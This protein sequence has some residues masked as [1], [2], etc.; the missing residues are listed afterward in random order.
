MIWKTKLPH[1]TPSDSRMSTVHN[2]RV[3][4]TKPKNKETRH[5]KTRHERLNKRKIKEES[6]SIL[7]FTRDYHRRLYTTLLLALRSVC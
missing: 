6:V 2:S 1:V 5:E 4:A 7:V 3:G